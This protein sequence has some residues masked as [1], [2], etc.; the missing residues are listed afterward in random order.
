MLAKEYLERLTKDDFGYASD[1]LTD[2]SKAL[3][4]IAQPT[5]DL[6]DAWLVLVDLYLV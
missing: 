4:F 1:I 5:K 3:A 2:E 6:R